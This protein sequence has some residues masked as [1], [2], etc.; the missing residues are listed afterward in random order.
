MSGS[1]ID[2]ISAAP[3]SSNIQPYAPSIMPTYAALQALMNYDTA[4]GI[5]RTY[6]LPA[7]TFQCLGPLSPPVGATL[8]GLGGDYRYPQTTILLSV[9]AYIK[10]DDGSRYQGFM[11][12][13]DAG[14]TN[15]HIFTASGAFGGKHRIQFRDISFTGGN[16][17][18][19]GLRLTNAS[20]IDGRILYFRGNC[21]GL[22]YDTSDNAPANPGDSY[23]SDI[24]AWLSGANTWGV[25]I[26]GQTNSGG[27][28][29]MNDVRID[30]LYVNSNA[31]NGGSWSSGGCY[32][33]D[34]INCDRITVDKLNA[35]ECQY[36][37]HAI[38]QSGG[39]AVATTQC[40]VQGECNDTLGNGITIDANATVR[41]DG[42]LGMWPTVDASSNLTGD[43]ISTASAVGTANPFSMR[44]LYLGRYGTS[45][46]HLGSVMTN[47]SGGTILANRAVK[48][49][50]ITGDPQIGVTPM[51]STDAI[52]SFVGITYMAESGQ[53]AVAS[54]GIVYV[55]TTGAVAIGDYL[56]IDPGNT[57]GRCISLGASQST[58]YFSIGQA[59]TAKGAGAGTV[60]VKLRAVEPKVAS[61]T[62]G[63]P[64]FDTSGMYLFGGT[65]Y[66]TSQR[67]VNLLEVAPLYL[68]EARTFQGIAVYVSAGQTNGKYRMCVYNDTGHG[69]PNTCVLDTGDADA[70]STGL[71]E[72]TG[73]PVTGTIPFTLNAGLYWVGG[74]N[75]SS[76]TN[77]TVVNTTVGL[78]AVPFPSGSLNSVSAT[79]G[80]AQ[81][82]VS[83][84]PTSPWTSTNPGGGIARV[85]LH[86]S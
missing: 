26:S 52:N 29:P 70:S 23:F 64:T 75:H 61:P 14:A 37:L 25:R 39:S 38:G 31:S 18:Y 78:F 63:Y 11:I 36:P 17:T 71:L 10:P 21:A 3:Q 19:A 20:E 57:D 79:F 85:S 46:H 43:W 15:E 74:V 16:S 59:M 48:V 82:S 27:T 40:W 9:G 81:T 58:S 6:V 4:Q 12:Q 22:L 77:I 80:Y 47:D 1:A 55:Q 60:Q 49:G 30:G 68:A 62:G 84:A 51:Q 73:T 8:M 86:V 66:S 41:F 34:L 56:G 76:G 7:G 67:T 24:F 35:E 54:Y 65:Q 32:G 42:Y 50:A 2:F 33:L 53:I 83:G 44:N 28:K 13:A 5:T 69:F 72:F 45:R